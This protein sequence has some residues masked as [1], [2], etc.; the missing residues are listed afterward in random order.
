M[1]NRIRNTFRGHVHIGHT[2]KT[3]EFLSLLHED[4]SPY[5]QVLPFCFPA[6]CSVYLHSGAPRRK[7]CQLLSTL[8]FWLLKSDKQ[9]KIR[10]KVC[11]VKNVK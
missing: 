8:C 2:L 5:F 1:K 4:V 11:L 6:L 7:I 3:A 10:K 9:I